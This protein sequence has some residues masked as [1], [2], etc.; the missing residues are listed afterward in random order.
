[1]LS[2]RTAFN[3]WSATRL[4]VAAAVAL[5]AAAAIVAVAVPRAG[6]STALPAANPPA[7][8]NG[9]ITKAA[10]D[11]AATDGATTTQSNAGVLTPVKKTDKYII[12]DTGTA[13]AAEKVAAPQDPICPNDEPCGP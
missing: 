5:L 11:K 8:I 1:M 13:G 4:G 9:T 3:R 10:T 7:T 6:G 12:L 2:S